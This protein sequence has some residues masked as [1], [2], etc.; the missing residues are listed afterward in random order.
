MYRGHVLH[1]H[2]VCVTPYYL[3]KPCGPGIDL[4]IGLWTRI[5]G[6]VSNLN[7]IE[8]DRLFKCAFTHYCRQCRKKVLFWELIDNR[9]KSWAR[10]KNKC[11]VSKTVEL[12]KIFPIRPF[13]DAANPFFSNA[14]AFT[15]VFPATES[16]TVVSPTRFSYRWFAYIVR[17]LSSSN[18]E[19]LDTG[20][21]YSTARTTP[22]LVSDAD[23]CARW[24]NNLKLAN[25]RRVLGVTGFQ[26]NWKLLVLS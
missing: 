9:E 8:C 20:D 5:L 25:K 19:Q 3:C 7:R 6:F 18:N 15:F 4:F 1:N 22:Q 14:T 10:D 26:E 23:T 17:S 12:P 16:P 24:W 21:F 11:F 13:A 2:K